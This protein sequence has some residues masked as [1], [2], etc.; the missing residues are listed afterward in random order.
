[1]YTRTKCFSSTRTKP[2]RVEQARTG[3]DIRNVGTIRRG[4]KKKKRK[5]KKESVHQQD[6]YA[7]NS[8]AF[9]P[10]KEV[11]MNLIFVRLHK[12]QTSQKM[13]FVR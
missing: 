5:K 7:S 9:T 6:W 13:I 12:W 11:D 2:A 1:M 4:S 8:K 3:L 10:A